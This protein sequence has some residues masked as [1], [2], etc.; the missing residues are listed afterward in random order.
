MTLFPEKMA[1]VISPGLMVI[2]L[3][4]PVPLAVAK[5]VPPAD[6]RI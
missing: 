2:L 4:G 5:V 1:L 3:G 6:P